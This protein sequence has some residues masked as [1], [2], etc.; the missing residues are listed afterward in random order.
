MSCRINTGQL[1]TV[2]LHNWHDIK[3]II[4]PPE[5]TWR[6][7][8]DILN[9]NNSFGKK[10]LCHILNVLQCKDIKSVKM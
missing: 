10:C 8:G 1:E 6:D 3:P 9:S 2:G 5:Q 4:Q 7:S